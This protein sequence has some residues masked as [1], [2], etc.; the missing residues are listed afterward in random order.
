[1]QTGFLYAAFH[2]LLATEVGP[3][4]TNTTSDHPVDEFGG[5]P[6]PTKTMPADDAR[7]D[8]TI[9][10]SELGVG[11]IETQGLGSDS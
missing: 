7:P 2:R 10:L 11:T 6:A 4:D 5:N 9:R 1:M 3:G 8:A